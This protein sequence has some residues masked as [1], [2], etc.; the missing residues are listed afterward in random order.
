MWETQR[1]QWKSVLVH[2]FI[3]SF[4]QMMV[5]LRDSDLMYGIYIHRNTYL[6]NLMDMRVQE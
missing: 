1:Q 6:E 3:P 4:I 2:S 5:A